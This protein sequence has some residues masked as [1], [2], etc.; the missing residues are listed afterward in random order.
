MMACATK[1]IILIIQKG[2]SWEGRELNFCRCLG[3][4]D[5]GI[6]G[7]YPKSDFQFSGWSNQKISF[8]RQVEQNFFFFISAEKLV[9]LLMIFFKISQML[10]WHQIS[11]GENEEKSCSICTLHPNHHQWEGKRRGILLI[12]KKIS[13]Q[14][15]FLNCGVKCLSRKMPPKCNP[16]SIL[17]LHIGCIL[18]AKDSY[19]YI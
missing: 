9:S 5:D 19:L 17:D 10:N 16:R 3:I 7:Q 11:R 13:T 18:V 14:F 8:D 2:V 1:K 4:N 15:F 12:F 6:I